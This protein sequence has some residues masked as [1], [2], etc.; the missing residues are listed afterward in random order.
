MPTVANKLHF[1]LWSSRTTNPIVPGTGGV[2]VS[3]TRSPR[4]SLEVTIPS[5]GNDDDE[6][7][8]QTK[9]DDDSEEEAEEERGERKRRG[10]DRWS[11]SG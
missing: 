7:I 4:H 9:S 5:L 10:G 8:T 1:I 6:W 3:S 2:H 11:R